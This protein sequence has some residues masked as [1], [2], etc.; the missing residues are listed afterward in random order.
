MGIEPMTLAS[1]YN[2]LLF[3]LQQTFNTA[4]WMEIY[5]ILSL[6]DSIHNYTVSPTQSQFDTMLGCGKLVANSYDL[7]QFCAICFHTVD[8][9]A[10]IFLYKNGKFWLWPLKCLNKNKKIIIKVYI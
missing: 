5:I 3:E 2:T 8:L 6:R 4:W 10:Y 1:L 7:I 9:H